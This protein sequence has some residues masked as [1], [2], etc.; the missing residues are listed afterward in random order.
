MW[1]AK[2]TSSVKFVIENE[3]DE[4]ESYPDPPIAPWVFREKCL[5]PIGSFPFIWGTSFPWNHGAVGERVR[6]YEVLKDFDRKIT[7]SPSVALRGSK[8][9]FVKATAMCFLVMQLRL[10]FFSI[11]IVTYLN[12]LQ[13][14][15]LKKK[16]SPVCL[17]LKINAPKLDAW[18]TNCLICGFLLGCLSPTDELQSKLLQACL[19]KDD[20]HTNAENDKTLLRV[21][22]YEK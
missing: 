4:T 20:R 6:R 9:H 16:P 14:K 15:N 17:W 11:Y 8:N 19:V 5:P 21:H 10:H 1:N 12:L 18:N 3:W 22:S 2:I 7:I 13:N